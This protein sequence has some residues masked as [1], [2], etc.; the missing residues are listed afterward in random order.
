[1]TTDTKTEAQ[2]FVQAIRDCK[3]ALTKVY[4]TVQHANI[5]T[6]INLNEFYEELIYLRGYADCMERFNIPIEQQEGE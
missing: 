1:M 4:S 6:D 3:R 5:V 2:E